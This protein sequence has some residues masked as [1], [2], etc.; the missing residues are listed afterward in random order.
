MQNAIFFLNQILPTLNEVENESIFYFFDLNPAE[1]VI[2]TLSVV[3]AVA[4]LENQHVSF[5]Y[6]YSCLTQSALISIELFIFSLGLTEYEF[7]QKDQELSRF[8]IFCSWFSRSLIVICVIC[9]SFLIYVISNPSSKIFR[10][11]RF[12]TFSDSGC[13]PISRIPLHHSCH[14]HN[15]FWYHW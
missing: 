13:C 2:G 5:F 8:S 9:K 14:F 10:P 1:K 4:E 12:V 15:A 7:E 3:T 6:L 11:C